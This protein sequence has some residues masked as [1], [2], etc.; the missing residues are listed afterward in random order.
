MSRYQRHNPDEPVRHDWTP[1][2][3]PSPQPWRD[4]GDLNSLRSTPKVLDDCREAKHVLS[5]RNLGRCYDEYSCAIC[6]ITFNI[7][8][9][10]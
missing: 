2:G 1:P 6:R 8:S 10:D 9:S 5:N 7:D 4:L 3:T